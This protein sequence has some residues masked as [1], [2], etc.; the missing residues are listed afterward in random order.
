MTKKKDLS[1]FYF[2]LSKNVAFGARVGENA[3]PAKDNQADNHIQEHQ[4]SLPETEVHPNSS[5][6]GKGVKGQAEIS[7]PQGLPEDAAQVVENTVSEGASVHGNP[8]TEQASS[9]QRGEPYK[10]SEDALAA[11]RERFLARKR[12]REQ[13][14]SKTFNASFIWGP[15][16]WS[17]ILWL[18]LDHFY[19]KFASR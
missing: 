13:E 7:H 16:G 6:G 15:F 18:K 19:V 12:A 8:Q 4:F 2:S 3:K 11:A 9:D 1:D 17:S 5:E 14:W 10:R